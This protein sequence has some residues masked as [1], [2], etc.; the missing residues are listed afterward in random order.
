MVTADDLKREPFLSGMRTAD[1]TRLATAARFTVVPEGRRL[2][3][4]RTPAERFW[5]LQEGTVDVDLHTP[6]RGRVV[7]ETLGPGSVVG[8]SWLFRPHLWRFGGVA[9]TPVTGIEFDGR[10]ARTLCAIDPS[11]GYELTRRFGELIVERLEA[12]RTWL[13]TPTGTPPTPSAML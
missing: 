4:E 6:D 8:W 10:L 13:T 11:L 12:A 7:I 5:L 2:F 9:T 1:L 3:E